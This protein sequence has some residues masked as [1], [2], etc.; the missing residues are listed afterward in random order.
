MATTPH[1][2]PFLKGLVLGGAIAAAALMGYAYG[3]EEAYD[4]AREDLEANCDVRVGFGRPSFGSQCNFDQVMVG[5]QNDYM[6]CADVEVQ[7]PD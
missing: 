6:L 3:T 7:C 1:R 5:I 4:T 2:T